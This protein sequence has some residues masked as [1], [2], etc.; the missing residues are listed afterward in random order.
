MRIG[1][2]KAMHFTNGKVK[3]VIGVASTFVALLSW[4]GL[5]SSW[6]GSVWAD[7]QFFGKNID[8][9]TN[10][11]P[12]RYVADFDGDGMVDSVFI[13]RIG[14]NALLAHDCRDLN[15][16]SNSAIRPSGEPLALVIVHGKS[17]HNSKRFLIHDSEFFS[18]PI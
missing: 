15:P 17:G 18:T 9:L 6:P 10:Q 7:S 16:W 4:Y 14:K 12:D 1:L 8:I 3:E 2:E 13:V 11:N 5:L